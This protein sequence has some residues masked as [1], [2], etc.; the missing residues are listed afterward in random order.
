[1]V[2]SNQSGPTP[3]G[4][5][6]RDGLNE[7]VTSKQKANNSGN[8]VREQKRVVSSW[9][10]WMETEYNVTTFDELKTRHLGEYAR[11]LKQRTHSGSISGRTAQLYFTRVR[12]FLTYARKW[13]YLTDNP[14]AK[15]RVLD[16]L[17]TQ[18]SGNDGPDQQ[19]WS[20]AERAQLT[21]YVDE[22]AHD[23]IDERGFD[24]VE[25]ARDRALVYVIAYSGVRVGELVRD[26]NDD[27]RKG[28]HWR[29]VDLE[30]GTISVLGK[31]QE[32]E[33]VQ[34][35][36]QAHPAIE[37][38][39]QILDPPSEGWPVFPTKHPPTLYAEARA[40]LPT[41]GVENVE[42]RLENADVSELLRE[43]DCPPPSITTDAVRKILRRL[44]K[45]GNI[46]VEGDH[47][48]LKPHGARRGVGEVLYR[49]KGHQAAQRALRHADPS[50]TSEMYAHIEASE[51]ADEAS[52]A[53]ENVDR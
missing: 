12:A 36:N 31:N 29:D 32:I 33:N 7:F 47:D 27:R 45:E 9:I 22:R 8:Y 2:Q 43:H 26:P 4:N 48:Y 49:E 19:F 5:T 10:D 52:D 11:Q 41:V 40:E 23:A 38:Y 3:Y 46:D 13:E 50:T 6:L 28:I 42:T 24:A 20:P 18:S 30:N 35:P 51:L 34:L 15:Q 53:F 1:M 17:P 25:E 16:E 39:R 37:R 44:C 21:R 14:A